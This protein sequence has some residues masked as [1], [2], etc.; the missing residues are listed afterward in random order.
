MKKLY[1]KRMSNAEIVEEI[2]VKN[3]NRYEKVLSG[4]LRNMDTENF[5]VDDSEF[6]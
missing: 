2:E 1:V 5:F 6:D 4:L 3:E